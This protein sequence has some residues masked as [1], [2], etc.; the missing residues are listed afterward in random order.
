VLILLKLSY[1]EKIPE[2][3]KI[4]IICALHKLDVDRIIVLERMGYISQAQG[5]E[6]VK[7][8]AREIETMRNN[9]EINRISYT[10]DKNAK[11]IEEFNGSD[12]ERIK[13]INKILDEENILYKQLTEAM[14][15]NQQLSAQEGAETQQSNNQSNGVQ[16]RKGWSGDSQNN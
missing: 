16:Q 9:I 7:T 10:L 2:T 1:S 14:E 5:L 3:D 13:F 15:K 12:E 4:R 8:T 6:D 11:L